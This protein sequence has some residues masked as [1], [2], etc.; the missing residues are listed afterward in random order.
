MVQSKI[1]LK[2]QVMERV[3]YSATHIYRLMANGLFPKQIRMS[4]NRVG[5]LESEIEQWILDKCAARNVATVSGVSHE[6]A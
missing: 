2:R 4:A 5:W 6:L 3:P 1:L